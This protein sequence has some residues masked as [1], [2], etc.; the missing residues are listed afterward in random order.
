M[1]RREN[2]SKWK[3]GSR[4]FKTVRKII[5]KKKKLKTKSVCAACYFILIFMIHL[6]CMFCNILFLSLVFTLVK[7]VIFFSF[8]HL[9]SHN[10][11]SIVN[12]YVLFGVI[13]LYYNFINAK[14]KIRIKKEPKS[15][16]QWKLSGYWIALVYKSSF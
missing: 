6:W 9:H 11:I 10:F 2:S 16:T 7:C 3:R 8:L 13:K 5:K 12:C 15:T 1:K 14:R 4:S